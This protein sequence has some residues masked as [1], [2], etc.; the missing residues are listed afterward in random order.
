MTPSSPTPPPMDARGATPNVV[1]SPEIRRGGAIGAGGAQ[2]AQ[3]FLWDEVCRGRHISS[4]G[5]TMSKTRGVL[6]VHS[7]PGALC[8]HVEWAVGGV[9]G[10][11]VRLEWTAQSAER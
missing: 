3:L 6:Y 10:V 2:W 5:G 9:L 11:P 1:K 4:L 8:P 7:A